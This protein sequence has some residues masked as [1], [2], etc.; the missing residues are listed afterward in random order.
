MLHDYDK[1]DMLITGS[2]LSFVHL[3]TLGKVLKFLWVCV[4]VCLCLITS[5]CQLCFSLDAGDTGN[6]FSLHSS[7]SSFFLFPFLLLLLNFPLLKNSS[8]PPFFHHLLP[9]LIYTSI[10]GYNSTSVL[11][12]MFSSSP[13]EGSSSCFVSIP[14]L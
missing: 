13:S 4:L 12:I 2:C 14:V 1:P 5:K 10:S 3:P 11:L 8:S 6:Y 9:P 7:S